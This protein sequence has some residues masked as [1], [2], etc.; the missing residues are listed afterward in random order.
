MF[1]MLDELLKW[2]T[3][4]GNEK[5]S[6]DVPPSYGP[7]VSVL[8]AKGVAVADTGKAVMGKL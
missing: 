3:G 6:T 1:C 2:R 8:H 7:S 4:Q 5:D